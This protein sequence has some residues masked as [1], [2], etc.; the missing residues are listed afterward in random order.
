MT[1]LTDAFSKKLNTAE[2]LRFMHYNFA[3]PHKALSKP[4]L[5][6]PAIRA[7]SRPR[8]VARGDSRAPRRRV[9]PIDQLGCMTWHGG[10]M[11]G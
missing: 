11:S 1:R 3:R 9:S 8:V 7:R 5:T 4:Y 6:T 2:A 10:R